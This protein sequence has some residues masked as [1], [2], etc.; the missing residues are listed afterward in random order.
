VS[1]VL[2]ASAVKTATLVVFAVLNALALFLIFNPW[3]EA[4]REQA[5]VVLLLEAVFL[6]AIGL[7]VFLHHWLRTGKSPRDSA[8]AAVDTV[9]T[10]LAGWV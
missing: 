9:M 10:F 6:V 7:P 3:I 1:D 2:G 4:W 5:L 8:S